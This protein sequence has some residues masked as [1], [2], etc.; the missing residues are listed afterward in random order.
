MNEE[1][2]G[3]PRH[4][5]CKKVRRARNSILLGDLGFFCFSVFPENSLFRG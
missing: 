5:G 4:G 3:G 2:I 1:V